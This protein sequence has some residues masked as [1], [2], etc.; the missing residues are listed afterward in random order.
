MKEVKKRIN[1]KKLSLN[2]KIE[3]LNKKTIQPN[4][5]LSNY[6]SYTNIYFLKILV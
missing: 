4:M 3:Q 1:K 6:F 5:H 2:K